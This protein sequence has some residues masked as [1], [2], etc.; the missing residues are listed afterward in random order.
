[1]SFVEFFEGLDGEEEQMPGRLLLLYFL[2]KALY[3][4]DLV[5]HDLVHVVN[6]VAPPFPGLSKEDGSAKKI[7][8]KH[9]I[10]K[11]SIRF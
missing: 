8:K 5:A 10:D 11:M 9:T 1:M 2:L 3:L 6:V 7:Y 4:P